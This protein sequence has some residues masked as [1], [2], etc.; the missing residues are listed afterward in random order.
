MHVCVFVASLTINEDESGR[1]GDYL[2]LLLTKDFLR[3]KLGRYLR[4]RR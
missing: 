1:K 3:F 2:N 4:Q